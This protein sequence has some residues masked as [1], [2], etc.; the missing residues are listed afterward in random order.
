MPNFEWQIRSVHSCRWRGRQAVASCI[1]PSG[2]PP[3]ARRL[4]ERRGL[5][6]C[7]TSNGRFVLCIRVVGGAGKRRL[8]ASD[9]RT[10]P[11]ELDGCLKD[12][13]FKFAQLRMADSFCA[14]VSLVALASCGFPAPNPD[15][16]LFLQDLRFSQETVCPLFNPSTSRA[17]SIA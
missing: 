3:R 6:I 12:E 13:V 14:F 9:R 11:L 4:L 10:L 7:P 8:P 17:W 2:A 16:G 1:R 15:C 5:S